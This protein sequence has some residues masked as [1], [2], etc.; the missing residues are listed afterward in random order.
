MWRSGKGTSA[1]DGSGLSGALLE[2]LDEM[3][4][5]GVLATH[6][7]EL[8]QLPLNLSSVS[9]KRM[10]LR[11]N[12]KN[13]PRWT[14]TIEDGTCTDS[15]ALHTARLH[16]ISPKIISRAEQL[17]ELFDQHC[18]PAATGDAPTTTV[19]TKR[20]KRKEQQAGDSTV[21]GEIV[22]SAGSSYKL[23]DLREAVAAVSGA[24]KV[25]L[26]ERGYEPPVS[27]EGKACVYVLHLVSPGRPDELYIGET[28]SIR[29]RL[30]QHRTVRK[31]VKIRALVAPAPNKS[32][33]RSVETRLIS[34]FKRLG[35]DIQQDK[36]QQHKLFAA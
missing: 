32:A 3:A 29:Q 5:T 11:F 8:F 33:A 26:V 6:L 35:Y 12:E 22:Q 24:E 34:E 20:G 21:A 14:Y 19:S 30:Q 17:V 10:G 2:A 27:L 28:E 9:N 36:D 25:V 16:G 1:R 31:G 15:L 7:H 18:R 13:V 4:V 23:E